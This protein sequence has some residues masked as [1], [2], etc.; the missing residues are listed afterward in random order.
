MSV[1][2]AISCVMLTLH[3]VWRYALLGAMPCLTLTLCNVCDAGFMLLAMLTLLCV[4]VAL[5]LSRL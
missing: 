5:T 1:V 2:D 4:T 3:R